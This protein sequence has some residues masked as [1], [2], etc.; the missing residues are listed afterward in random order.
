MRKLVKFVFSISLLG[1]LC[2]ML[3]APAAHADTLY[4]MN[5]TTTHGQPLTSGVID[6][7]DAACDTSITATTVWE[8][9]TFTWSNTDLTTGL[10]SIGSLSNNISCSNTSSSAYAF[11]LLDGCDGLNGWYATVAGP[12][13]GLATPSPFNFERFNDG[14]NGSLDGG[15]QSGFGT[16]TLTLIPPTSAP[17]PITGVLMLMGLGLLGLIMVRRKRMARGQPLAG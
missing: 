2:L 1:L 4:Q 9:L 14:A 8:G 3:G 10:P 6:C 7:N 11:Q 5:F 17:E 13:V 16:F 12:S 15:A